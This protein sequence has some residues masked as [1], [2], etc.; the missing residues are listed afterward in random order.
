M[1]DF[2]LHISEILDQIIQ[3]IPVFAPELI[4]IA[5]FIL[6]VIATLAFDRYWKHSSFVV[7]ILGFVGSAVEVTSQIGNPQS[8]F[9]YMI[10]IDDLSVYARLII[11]FG[12]LLSAI[13]IQQHFS[14]KKTTKKLG[15]IYSILLTAALGVHLLTITSNWLL[16]FIAIETV[17][18]SSYILVGYFSENKKQSEAAM[19]YVLF[20]SV[21]AAVMLYGIS[22]LYGFTGNLDFITSQHING[23]IDAPEVLVSI[24]I[25]FVLVGI[26]FKLSFVPFH[27]WSPDVYEG[28]PTPITAFLSTVPKIGALILLARLFEAWSTT[29]F[30]FSEL[31]FFTIAITGIATM[32]IGNLVALRQNNIKRM[33]AY[34]SIGHTGFLLMAIVV[35]NTLA[36]QSFLFYIAI[37]TIMNLSVFAFVDIIEQRT[38]TTAITSYAG[39]GKHMPI[40]FTLFT[41]LGISLV[42]LPPTAGFVGKVLVFTSV[43]EVYQT[44]QEVMYL[45]MMIAGALTSVISLF[46]YFKIPL[47]AFLRPGDNEIKLSQKNTVVYVIGLVLAI[48]SII[49]G[50]FPSLL[51]RLF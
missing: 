50:I 49:L 9:L 3:S 8:G 15:D 13:F 12:C 39:L 40:L 45:L 16:A 44:S 30:Y 43:F 46:Y 24:A 35:V 41:L 6:S 20:G 47:Y 17:S 26:G 19:K 22:L 25:I 18:I 34:S 32:L 33:M 4:L 11:L 14:S 10:T 21:S 29:G 5:A 51:L 28:A 38:R 2:S 31:L 7:A 23:L 37:Y 1:K 27:V 36:P 48:S 42:G